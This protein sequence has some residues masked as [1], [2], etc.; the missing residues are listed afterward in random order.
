MHVA[1]LIAFITAFAAAMAAPSAQKDGSELPAPSMSNLEDRQPLNAF[2]G[3]RRFMDGSTNAVKRGH[4]RH[5]RAAHG[6]TPN[7]RVKT[8]TRK[9]KKRSGSC[10]AKSSSATLSVTKSATDYYV[11]SSAA[12]ATSTPNLNNGAVDLLTSSASSTAVQSTRVTSVRATSTSTSSSAPAT[13]SSASTWTS[14]DPDGNGP[15]SGEITYY[16][17]GTD[18][19]AIGACG[20]NLVDSDKVSYSSMTS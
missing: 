8:P 7:K 17:L 1:H 15:F 6:R 13:T 16:D 3:S 20:T 19:S 9:V 5:G 4:Q 2:H 18:G 12:G 11:S 10:A 14:V